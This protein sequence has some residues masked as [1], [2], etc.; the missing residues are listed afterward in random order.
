M[1]HEEIYSVLD[2]QSTEGIGLVPARLLLN[3]ANNRLRA[4]NHLLE[5]VRLWASFNSRQ[6]SDNEI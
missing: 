4:L 5:E 1:L 6:W 3:C 2:A